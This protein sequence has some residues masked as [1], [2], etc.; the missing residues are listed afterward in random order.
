MNGEARRQG[1]LRRLTG[2]DHPISATVL[3]EEF[4]VSRQIIVQD[5][6]LLRATG[7]KITSLARGYFLQSAGSY[8]RVFKVIHSDED[9]EQ[10]LH[11]IVDMG[12]IVDDVFVY[13]RTYG[14]IRAEMGIRSRL[15]VKKFLAEISSG[16]SSM[17]KNVTDGYHYHTIFADSEEQL[18]QI[19]EVLR[20]KGFLAP[21]QE[22]EPEELD[23]KLTR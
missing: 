22:Y 13:H 15:D 16:K 3:A 19:G 5:I 8:R 6:A 12:G 9:T 11:T 20:E 2:A 23:R 4:G 14:K 17:L 7:S 1:I 18:D 10:E 21:L